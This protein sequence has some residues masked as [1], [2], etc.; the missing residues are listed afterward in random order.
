MGY[1]PRPAIVA[2]QI[3]PTPVYL[4]PAPPRSP[5]LEFGV[6]GLVGVQCLML[7][8]LAWQTFMFASQANDGRVEPASDLAH[9]QPGDRQRLY[10]VE[11]LVAVQRQVLQD[12]VAAVGGDVDLA[13]KLEQLEYENRRNRSSLQAQAFMNQELL[14]ENQRLKVSEQR[15][16]VALAEQ[17]SRLDASVKDLASVQQQIR[18]S[19]ETAGEARLE[20]QVLQTWYQ[21]G[22]YWFV[23]FGVGGVGLL[24]G[25]AAMAYL[26]R[27]E[28]QRFPEAREMGAS[29]HGEADAVYSAEDSAASSPSH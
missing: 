26:R 17:K 20:S 15:L 16:E 4:P 23:L 10:E 29:V 24:A 9:Q 5:W 18:E 6:F 13:A 11:A 14:D 19:V 25:A 21:G 2:G 12:M 8:F 22:F 7:V 1:D 28:S 3:Q 27:D